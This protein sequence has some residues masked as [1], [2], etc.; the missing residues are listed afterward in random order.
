M[1]RLELND[2][3]QR[4]L[5]TMLASYLSELKIEVGRTDRHA[6]RQDLRHKE[7]IIKQIQGKVNRSGLDDREREILV[8]VLH[9]Y[10]SELKTEVS[11]TDAK[12]YRAELRDQEQILNQ[13]RG[14]VEQL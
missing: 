3:E 4:M 1:V 8:D 2:T 7:L 11:H 13:I 9:S 10:L 14:K 5:D 6:Y 12:A